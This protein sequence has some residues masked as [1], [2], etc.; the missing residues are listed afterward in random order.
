MLASF[1]C[2]LDRFTTS[3]ITWEDKFIP[4]LNFSLSLPWCCSGSP[5]PL[6]TANRTWQNFT[7]SPTPPPSTWSSSHYWLKSYANVKWW[8]SKGMIFLVVKVQQGGSATNGATPSSYSGGVS[9]LATQE[10]EAASRNMLR[11]LECPP[12]VTTSTLCSY[13]CRAPPSVRRGNFG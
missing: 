9:H 11:K 4:G 13:T 6:A 3:N 8:I 12:W 2:W 10:D 1:R 5:S 7:L